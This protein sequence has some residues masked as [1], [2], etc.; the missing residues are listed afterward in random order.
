MR[1]QILSI[2]LAVL[3]ALNLSF[4]AAD[5]TA[6]QKPQDDQS[7]SLDF[8]DGLF[9]RGMYDSA[10]QEY[11]RIRAQHPADDVRRTIEFR[12]AEAYFKKA[13]YAKAQELFTA[14]GKKY[15]GAFAEQAKL[16]LALIALA[17]KKYPE[18][19]G[20]FEQL[21]ISTLDE[22]RAMQAYY[23]YGRVLEAV[24]RYADAIVQFEKVHDTETT[25]LRALALQNEA[26]CYKLLGKID[27]ANQVL[28]RLVTDYP[29]RS[30]IASMYLALG[31]NYFEAG[32]FKQSLA[33]FLQAKE[34]GVSAENA[35]LLQYG[36]LK[37]Y[38]QL[39]KM[40]EVIATAEELRKRTLPDEIKAE[41]LYLLAS[42]YFQKGV[43]PQA[44]AV[45]E[46]AY[47]MCAT[48][49]S[50]V[51]RV[52]VQALWIFFKLGDDAKRTEY[53]TLL[54]QQYPE[55]LSLAEAYFLEAERCREKGDYEKAAVYYDKVL[56]RNPVFRYNDY[57]AYNKACM[58]NKAG[59]DE[60]ALQAFMAFI[61]RYPASEHTEAAFLA[62]LSLGEQQKQYETAL[63]LAKRYLKQFPAGEH[64]EAVYMKKAKM[65]YELGLYEDMRTTLETT[66][67][68]FPDAPDKRDILFNLGRYYERVENFTEAA[69]YYTEAEAAPAE[70]SIITTG[71]V[72]ARLGIVYYFLT[73]YD[74]AEAALQQC[75]AQNAIDRIPQDILVWLGEYLGKKEHYDDALKVYTYA[76]SKEN[77]P[78]IKERMLYKVAEWYRE[79]HDWDHAQA[80]YEEL[81]KTYPNGELKLFAQLG[82]AQCYEARGDNGEARK[83]YQALAKTDVPYIKSRVYQGLGN[84]YYAEGNLKEAV[85]SYMFVTILFDDEIVPELMIKSAE[86][87]I[88]LHDLIDAKTV[89]DEFDKRF[90]DHPLRGKADALRQK[91]QENTVAP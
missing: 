3:M 58:L 41:V 28:E 48:V 45:I 78:D 63:S 85:R 32:D 1:R 6:S 77:A 39:G 56:T 14:Y 62:A 54:E 68:L 73:D 27:R 83:R 24:Q 21:D 51:E 49:P 52:I 74:Q 44:A 13:E 30:G 86:I 35:V 88:Q 72:F 71:E 31:R 70:G 47:A 18:A 16:Q 82:I 12:I 67:S 90:A 61:D 59:Q 69:R 9:I 81:E 37:N 64:R 79:K 40:D 87:W 65:E 34:K 22:N 42:A 25:E 60:K 80:S 43:Y 38:F 76:L 89:L 29:D 10:I 17:Q 7:W 33:Y 15:T 84:I 11:E 20:Y 91:L 55:S 57:V 75:L 19:I 46:E 2:G 4:A 36:I 23:S 50:Y 26:D 53:T 5:D 66:L 8:A